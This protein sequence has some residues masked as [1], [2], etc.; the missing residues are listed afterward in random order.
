MN[1]LEH[2]FVAE[3]VVNYQSGQLSRR[4]LILRVLNIT[5]GV[6]STASI[7]TLLGCGGSSIPS[8]AQGSATAPASPAPTPISYLSAAASSSSPST[9]GTKPGG[10]AASAAEKPGASSG[11][12]NAKSPFSVA[13]D[14]PTID[15]RDI[16][17]QGNGATLMAY[18]AR[19]KNATGPLP[20]V[21]VCEENAGVDAHIRDVTRR[22]AKAGYL[23]SALDLLSRDGGT[24]KVRA[25]DASRI[26][27]LLSGGD[28]ATRHVAD[29][30]T[31][32]DYYA[33]ASGAK[34]GAVGMVGFCFGGGIT[35]RVAAELPTLKAAVPYYGTAQ[36]DALKNIKAA[37]L[38][39]Y[40][41]DANDGATK[42]R[43]AVEAALRGAGVTA[44]IKQYPGTTH[45]FNNDMRQTSGSGLLYNPEQA[46]AAWNDT[47]DWLNKYLKR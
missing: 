4:D 39:V 41:G 22:L 40:D 18:E 29:F 33:N 9:A 28:A 37:V 11:V 44:Q 8:T 14:D 3:Y 24:A 43:A 32:A 47:L 1:E 5:G 6:A 12:P 10:S 30:R 38:A 17:F 46:T 20:V 27:A 16:T 34:P 45:G 25:T 19:P 23:A 26:G 13:V 35:W 21:M 36:L 2:Y 31:L 42:Q 7:L 15:T